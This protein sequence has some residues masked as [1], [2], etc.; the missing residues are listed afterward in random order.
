MSLRLGLLLALLLGLCLR[1]WDL[2]GPSLWLDEIGQVMAARA[3]WSAL[4]E[5]V[6]QHLSPPLDYGILKVGQAVFGQ[7]DTAVRVPA[8]IFGLV[9]IVL[10]AAW[11]RMTLGESSARWMA[12]LMALSPFA[13]A[14]AREARMYS[15][16]LAESAAAWLLLERFLVRPHWGRAAALGAMLGAALL[17]HYYGAALALGVLAVGLW[18]RPAELPRLAMAGLLALALFAPWAPWFIE[19][20]K[21]SGGQIGYGLWPRPSF[22][23]AILSAL[24]SNSGFRDPWF[25]GMG[26]AA[27]AGAWVGR[28]EAAVRAAAAVL[29]LTL[30]AFFLLAFWRLTSTER[31]FIFLLPLFLLLLA[32]ALQGVEAALAQRWGSRTTWVLAALLLAVMAPAL[33]AQLTRGRHG[34]QP[35][36]KL[37]A[38]WLDREE[39]SAPYWVPDPHSRGCLAYYLEPGAPYVFMGSRSLDSANQAGDRTR[40]MGPDELELARL[41]RLSG[42]LVLPNWPLSFSPGPEGVPAYQALYESSATRIHGQRPE[43]QIRILKA[44]P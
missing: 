16:L 14:Y 35:E 39:A 31:N 5:Q 4:P 8:L 10:S 34:Y 32:R 1:A 40:V 11:A 29:A 24:S 6:V 36:W 22:F 25:Y 7:S 30:I 28:R 12:L 3:P 15:L 21:A 13:I 17:T 38:A 20:L 37:A 23:K 26:A 41:G 27:L 43:G 19:Q 9:A 33:L 18:R 44:G 2:G 42:V